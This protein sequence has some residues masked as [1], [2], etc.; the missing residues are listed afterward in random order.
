MKQHIATSS[1]YVD[2]NYHTNITVIDII[3]NIMIHI[4]FDLNHDL[5]TSSLGKYEVVHFDIV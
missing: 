2:Q 4:M 5:K 3:M 1:G